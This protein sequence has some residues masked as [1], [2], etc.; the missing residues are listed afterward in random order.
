MCSIR[1][2]KASFATIIER[3][4]SMEE[5]VEWGIESNR[6]NRAKHFAAP[7]CGA[8]AMCERAVLVN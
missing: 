8:G 6:V 5:L 1:E 2:A 3:P 4:M 7:V